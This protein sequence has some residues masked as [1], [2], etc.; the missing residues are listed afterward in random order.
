V[1]FLSRRGK[2]GVIGSQGKKKAS[3]GWEDETEGGR[4]KI[5]GSLSLIKKTRGRRINCLP[6]GEK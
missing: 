1:E 3:E 4:G 6:F 2:G 5:C